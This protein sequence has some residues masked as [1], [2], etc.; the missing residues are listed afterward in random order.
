MWRRKPFLKF[1]LPIVFVWMSHPSDRLLCQ[2]IIPENIPVSKNGREYKNPWAGGMNNPQFS[3]ADLNFDGKNELIVFDRASNTINVFLYDDGNYLFSR[4]LSSVFP[5][6]INFCLVRDF[7]NDGIPDL[8]TFSHP[9]PV[10]GIKVFK[11]VKNASGELSFKDLDHNQGKFPN[12]LH[13]QSLSNRSNIY[14]AVTDIPVIDD[15]DGDGDLD[16]LS[17][18]PSGGRIWYYRNMSIEYGFGGDSLIFIREDA[19]WGKIL[20]G[21]SFDEILLS[22][23]PNTCASYSN[24]FIETR[25][26]GSNMVAIDQNNNGLKDIIITDIDVKEV[27]LF[28]N[29]GTEQRGW[30]TEIIHDYP[31]SHPVDI[32]IFPASFHVDINHDGLKDLIFSP[33]LNNP[34]TE[35]IETA[36]YYENIGTI[37]NQQFE[38][39]KND[40][41]SDDML[42]FG[43][44]SVPAIADVTGNGL[45]DIVV[46]VHSKYVG[47]TA[48]NHILSYLV[49]IENV[50]TVSAPVFEV[51]DDDWLGLSQL[52][53]SF[54]GFAPAFGDLDGDG[55]LDLLLGTSEGKFIYLE[56]IAGTGRR[57]RFSSPVINAFGIESGRN[58]IPCIADVDNDGLLDIL[59]GENLGSLML[60]KNIGSADTPQFS[61][62]HNAGKSFPFFAKI[63]VRE[64]PVPGAAAPFFFKSNGYSY[65]AAGRADKG[66]LLFENAGRFD[67]Y[68][69]RGVMENTKLAGENTSVAMADLNNSGKLAMVIGNIRGGLNII[70]TDII[71]DERRVENPEFSD[72]ILL[73][74]NPV[75][76]I[77]NI[78]YKNAKEEERF[79]LEVYSIAGV[80]IKTILNVSLFEEYPLRVSDMPSGIYIIKI[81][82]KNAQKTKKITV[83]K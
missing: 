7:N 2:E 65:I 36:W 34:F 75:T 60:F 10:S 28:R 80:L 70:S 16:I 56:N 24:A 32:N 23:D 17:F 67:E 64:N 72:I 68:I 25:H 20:E 14:C 81:V 59:V 9:D 73:Y 78:L 77:I 26:A 29:T 15:I 71:A 79:N 11:G 8:F 35:T 52:G 33:G 57:M 42:D 49:L 62:D 4:E 51:R 6:M 37:D 18:E 21:P 3:E 13:Y 22:N 74:P 58:A 38:W 63:D 53:K 83:I 41:L 39:Q 27:K 55:D 54:F 1:L 47:S 61:K 48:E 69:S 43:A 30:I 44:G 40:F 66:V 50:G 19:C 31:P 12:V 46:G 45:L 76:D 82:G 5:D